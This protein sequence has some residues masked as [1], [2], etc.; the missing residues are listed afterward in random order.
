MSSIQPSVSADGQWVAY[1]SQATNL[2]VGDTNGTHDIFLW[3]RATGATTRASVTT[4]GDQSGGGSVEPS[5]SADGRYVAFTSFGVLDPMVTYATSDVWVYDRVTED[6]ELMSISVTNTD[7]IQTSASPSIS[8]NGSLVAFS[9]MAWNLVADDGDSRVDIFVRDRD[10]GTT[11][12]VNLP[13][14]LLEADGHSGWPV[15]SADGTTVAFHS[16]ATNLVAGDSNGVVDVFVTEL[17]TGT[18]ER[19][20]IDSSE[21][22]STG[23]SVYAEL[24]GD[25][26]FVAFLS[27]GAL[28]TTGT[29]GLYDLYVRDRTAGTTAHTSVG[30][31]GQPN[32]DFVMDPVG[33][34]DDG[35]TVVFSTPDETLSAPLTENNGEIDVFLIANPLAP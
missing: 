3:E 35:S 26:R 28:D 5:L 6:V 19:A 14:G 10:A 33:F 15:I 16:I 7:G 24:S 4:S 18:L 9:S 20:S 11:S 8:A 30:C 23:T 25:G 17:A 27:E 21:V 22:Q 32:E 34:A 31:D 29:I 2:V 1:S 12:R 13:I